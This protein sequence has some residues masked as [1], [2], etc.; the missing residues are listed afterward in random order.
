MVS[1]NED[2]QEVI[3]TQNMVNKQLDKTLCFN[4]VFGSGSKE[5]YLY[6]QVVA[7]IAKESFVGPFFLMGKRG[8]AGEAG[9]INKSLLTLG[10][11]ALKDIWSKTPTDMVE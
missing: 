7:T 4:K 11:L 10:G 2:T 5:N 8:R 6:D 9:E 1:C 3:A